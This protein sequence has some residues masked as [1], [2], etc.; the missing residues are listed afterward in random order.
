MEPLSFEPESESCSADAEVRY[1]R[2]L[3]AEEVAELETLC[4]YLGHRSP[5]REIAQ[6][7]L[8]QHELRSRGFSR[9]KSV[10]E[11]PSV[12]VWRQQIASLW[13]LSHATLEPFWK[14]ISGGTLHKILQRRLPADTKRMDRAGMRLVGITL[15]A[16]VLIG[17]NVA[18]AGE[19][20]GMLPLLFTGT[21][22]VLAPLIIPASLMYDDSRLNRVRAAAATALGH[23]RLPE[24]VSILAASVYDSPRGEQTTG[25]HRVRQAAARALPEVLAALTSE[26]Y[27]RL[28]AET[29]PNLCRLLHHPSTALVRDVLEALEKVG[30]GRA[31]Q[32]VERLIQRGRNEAIC[33]RAEAILPALLER[34]RQEQAPHVLLR[35]TCK[36]ET[37]SAHLLRPAQGTVESQPQQLL[38]A[39]ES[40][41]S[42]SNGL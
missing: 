36:P 41:L 12:A 31:V 13:I 42:A 18:E 28:P 21:M 39:S 20:F 26:H 5:V 32:P 33:A 38:R 8:H 16:D 25:C 4:Q 3:C 1:A 10:L 30:D 24:S 27:G 35:P 6:E 15:L 7:V 19:L 29:V 34:Q 37:P 23:L 40:D 2:V 17:L 11:N 22:A 14:T 9:L